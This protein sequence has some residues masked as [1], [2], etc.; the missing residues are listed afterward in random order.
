MA[1]NGKDQPLR[2]PLSRALP[3]GRR[4][5]REP[6]RLPVGYETAAYVYPPLNG[7]ATLFGKSTAGVIV[8]DS[9]Q[10]ATA[11]EAIVAAYAALQVISS[12]AKNRLAIDPKALEQV[13]RALAMIESY[14]DDMDA[15]MDDMANA[16]VY[17]CREWDNAQAGG[18]L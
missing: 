16:D 5:A 9:P 14:Q 3:P 8:L 13:E 4:P 6:L 17:G 7:T 18:S 11:D 15:H 12:D 10:P 1:G 2:L